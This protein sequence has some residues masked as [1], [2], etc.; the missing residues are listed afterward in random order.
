ME[1]CTRCGQHDARHLIYRTSQRENLCCFCHV[2]EGGTPADWHPDCLSAYRS[3][4]E[5]SMDMIELTISDGEETF[6]LTAMPGWTGG[7]VGSIDQVIDDERFD[8]FGRTQYN[9]K[10]Q[11]AT[12]GECLLALMRALFPSLGIRE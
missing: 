9:D 5:R 1:P 12:A 6:V 8:A 7:I 11:Y 3:N 10:T 4:Q 2:A